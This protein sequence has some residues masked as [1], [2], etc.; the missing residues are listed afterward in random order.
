MDEVTDMTS[1]YTL[2]SSVINNKLHSLLTI[3][4]SYYNIANS[5]SLEALMY[6]ALIN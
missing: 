3:A 2:Q 4:Y 5:V 6:D 1:F